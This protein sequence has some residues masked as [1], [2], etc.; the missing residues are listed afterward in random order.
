MM[1]VYMES[2]MELGTIFEV[3]YIGADVHTVS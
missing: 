2:R 1:G 3:E